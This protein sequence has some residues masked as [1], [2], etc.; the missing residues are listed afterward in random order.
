MI[1]IIGGFSPSAFLV[2][3][4]QLP[5]ETFDLPSTLQIPSVLICG[6]VC[7]PRAGLISIIAYLTIGLFYIPIFHGGGST[8]YLNTPEM[9]YLFGFIP[10]IW[11]SGTLSDKQDEKS[12]IYLTFCSVIGLLVIHLIGITNLIIGGLTSRWVQNTYELIMSYSILPFL[13]HIILCIGVGVIAKGLR[14]ILI[15]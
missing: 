5:P 12:F 10:A 11:I 15:K 7:G 3:K 13:T 4:F 14:T 2:P 1:I 8:G 9:G 6:L